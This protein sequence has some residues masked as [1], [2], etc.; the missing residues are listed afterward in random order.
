MEIE[1]QVSTSSARSMRLALSL[2]VGPWS[3]PTERLALLR[4]SGLT[5]FTD[6]ES[7]SRATMESG[8]SQQLNLRRARPL[9]GPH[10]YRKFASSWP[11]T[12]AAKD[13]TGSPPG[14][15][16]CRGPWPLGRRGGPS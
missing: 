11:K 10:F 2:S 9:A 13:G 4:T 1:L 16:N 12:L 7:G 14:D 8:L 3:S 15:W 5:N 6:C